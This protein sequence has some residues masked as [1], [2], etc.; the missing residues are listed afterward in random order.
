MEIIGSEFDCDC[1]KVLVQT[2]QLARSRYRNDPRLLGEEPR[3]RDLSRRRL[4]SVCDLAEQIDDRLVGFPSL[5]SEAREPGSNVGRVEGH[6][7]INF[8]REKALPQRAPRNESD[9]E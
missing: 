5:R 6:G 3:E 4:L 1:S 8:R 7:G 9:P 2:L